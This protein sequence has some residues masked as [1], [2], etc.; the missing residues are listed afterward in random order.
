MNT[1]L[2]EP[3]QGDQSRR[4]ACDRCRGQKL[5]CE[6]LSSNSSSDDF[7]RR[8]LKAGV[9]C[10]TTFSHRINKPRP[11]VAS[12]SMSLGRFDNMSPPGFE[13]DNR[14]TPTSSGPLLSP[15][16]RPI[17]SPMRTTGDIHLD[18]P[19]VPDMSTSDF[20]EF[21]H[22]FIDGDT[23]RV[24]SGDGS[25]DSNPIDPSL[26]IDSHDS[27]PR[28]L[29]NDIAP[30][31]SSYR[32]PYISCRQG[33][34]NSEV[35]LVQRVKDSWN[36]R[37]SDL[38]ATLLEDLTLIESGKVA[39]TF[40]FS[41]MPRQ[42]TSMSTDQPGSKQYVIENMLNRSEELLHILREFQSSQ[43]RARAGANTS[44]ERGSPSLVGGD[45]SPPRCTSPRESIPVPVPSSLSS[46]PP[47]KPA[48]DN[49]TEVLDPVLT[50][51]IL[52]CYASL[53]RIYHGIFSLI[54]DSVVEAGA[55][56]SN[57]LPTLP[58]IHIDGFE[59]GRRR[60]LHIRILI[61]VSSHLVSQIEDCMNTMRMEMD[62]GIQGRLFDAV[63]PRPDGNVC[64]D[65]GMKKSLSQIC[66][67]IKSHLSD[68]SD[69]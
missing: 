53:L 16:L 54:R 10:V 33:S 3:S 52:T 58:N 66:R 60:D 56:G 44:R 13:P 9:R 25:D 7:C 61:Q 48:P 5:R 23:S 49:D 62:R 32:S 50:L 27:A 4:S 47:P 11:S 40:L 59:V 30:Q 21:T 2:Q 20:F 64:D 57:F 19:H 26:V 28:P 24:Q 41:S 68:C 38:S 15:Q 46:L 22:A 39:G 29:H 63:L 45:A 36:E 37:F 6:R 12:S 69:F 42:Q 8:C 43:P 67:A 14:L 55:P 1:A 35:T 18:A 65:W 17:A 34:T 31:E 51:L